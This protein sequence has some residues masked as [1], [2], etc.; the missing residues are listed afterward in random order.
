M[1][2]DISVFYRC[3]LDG[4]HDTMYTHSLR[5]FYHDCRIAGTINFVFGGAAAIFQNC[6]L[7]ARTPLPGQKNFVTA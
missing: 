4:H 2:S 3:A 6:H 7:L 5:Q 1:R